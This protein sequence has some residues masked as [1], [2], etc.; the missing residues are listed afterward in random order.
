MLVPVLALAAVT[1]AASTPIFAQA[2]SDPAAKAAA[3]PGATVPLADN[4][5]AGGMPGM[6][7][8][9][10]MRQMMG[11]EEPGAMPWMRHMTMRHA[12]MGGSPRARCEERLARRAGLRA[13]VE[14]KLNLTPAQRPLWEKVQAAAQE[15][16]RQERQLCDAAKPGASPNVVARLDRREQFLS[17]RLAGL[18]SAKPA[19]A[20]L[21]DALS[22]EQK[23]IIDHP[24]RMP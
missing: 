20:A 10:G 18:K 16:A 21:Y 4:G 6:P 24:F 17:V 15:E 11:G 7:G 12:M 22:P 9:W 3:N 8:R 23:N 13:Y 5:E 14:A 2:G 1:V 19:V